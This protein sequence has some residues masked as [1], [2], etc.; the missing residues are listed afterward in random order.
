MK[1]GKFVPKQPSGVET[2]KVIKSS[3]SGGKEGST[4]NLR[5]KSWDT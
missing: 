4:A 5:I 2:S 1:Q 3:V